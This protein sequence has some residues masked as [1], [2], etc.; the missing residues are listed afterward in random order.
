MI[1][2]ILRSC[3]TVALAVCAS[4]VLSAAEPE[5]KVGLA[6]VKVTPDKPLLLSGYANRTKPYESVAADIYC[7]AIVLEDRDG[8]L[9]AIVTSDLLGFPADVAEPICMRIEQKIGLKRSQILLNSSHSH[10]GPQLTLK[11]PA[12]NGSGEALR[13]VEYTRQLQDKVVDLV[14][15]AAE[16]LEPASLSWGTGVINFAMNRREF[17]PNGVILG[18][19]PRGLADRSVPLL[20]IDGADG[21]LR[22][23]LFGTAV[24]G[25]TLTGD[26]YQLCGDFAGYAQAAL[27]ERM[28]SVQ[29]F[30]MLGCAGDDNPYPRGTMALAIKHGQNLAD[31]VVRILETKLRPVHGPLTIAFDYAELPLQTGFSRAD[32]EKI[33]A[34]RRDS[35][36]FAATQ[37]LAILSRGEKLPDTYR[38]PFAVWQLGQDLTLVGLPGEVVVD[39][40]TMLEKALGPNQ[41]WIAA[42][43]NDVFGY[44]PSARVLSEGGYE[45]RGL[46]SGSAGLFDPKSEQVVVQT[47]RELAKKAGRKLPE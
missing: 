33:A 25:T 40:V 24:H 6:S 13:N 14:C 3:A 1:S 12:K 47:V 46:Y 30:Y 43:C 4:F 44:L 5:W 36:N 9:A 37:M 29:A 34:N 7:K 45:T 16:K 15:S 31:E 18:V 10:A 22:A 2:M 20:R 35:R 11:A 19:N 21:K 28:P 27:Q 23:V 26:N 17:T 38:C 39:Y 41:L 8:H 32:L 42:Y